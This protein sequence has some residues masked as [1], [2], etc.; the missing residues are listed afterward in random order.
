MR[1]HTRPSWL[2]LLFLLPFGGWTQQ[3]PTPKPSQSSP[4]QAAT[5]S[6]KLEEV[7]QS[8]ITAEWEA[9]K[10]KNKKAYSDLL[11]DDF[12]A[13][14][15]DGQGQRTK[16][17][18]VNEIDRSVIS[19]YRLFAVTVIPL[20]LNSALVTYEITFQFPPK[21]VVRFKRV[22]VSETWLRRNGQ[23][24]ERYYQETHVR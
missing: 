19:D 12:V 7:L 23:W 8:N 5:A 10:N 2:L 6:M 4:S 22:L 14:E 18:A 16:A 15:D 3:Q 24:K 20:S 17:A 1:L 9:F 11:A 21:S 13:V